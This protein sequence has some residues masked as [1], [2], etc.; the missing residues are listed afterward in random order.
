MM[1][2]VAPFTMGRDSLLYRRQLRPRASRSKRLGASLL[3]A[4]EL[5]LAAGSW[6]DSAALARS[7]PPA[8]SVQVPCIEESPAG[9]DDRA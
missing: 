2:T 3:V 7:E 9:A 1:T 8:Q 5:A 4:S 6:L